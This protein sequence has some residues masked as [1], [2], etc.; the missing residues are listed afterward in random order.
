EEA[1]RRVLG[2]LRAVRAQFTA[3]ERR[4]LQDADTRHSWST[5]LARS[6]QSR[7]GAL[8]HASGPWRT[9]QVRV[10]PGRESLGPQAAELAVL[11]RDETSMARAIRDA[12]TERAG[13]RG[14]DGRTGRRR[15]GEWRIAMSRSARR[16]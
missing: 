11:V 4:Q 8:Q 6:G 9:E 12:G 13:A 14:A 7:T 16:L 2:R 15:D 10:L 3:H 5:R 1:L